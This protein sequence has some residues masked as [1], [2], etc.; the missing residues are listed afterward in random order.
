LPSEAK[1]PVAAADDT[2]PTNTTGGARRLRV[3]EE[4][5][6]GAF[7]R[8]NAISFLSLEDSES[9][10]GQGKPP[11]PRRQKFVIKRLQKTLR[12]RF[13]SSFIRTIHADLE[14]EGRILAQL[15]HPNIIRLHSCIPYQGSSQFDSMH[16]NVDISRT[17][18]SVDCS[19]HYSVG[20]S[21]DVLV[22]ERLFG[23][24]EDK[25]SSKQ[26]F[27]GKA[28]SRLP[29]VSHPEKHRIEIE[30][31]QR[32]IALPVASALTYLHS[33]RIIFVSDYVFVLYFSGITL[34]QNMTFLRS[35]FVT[36]AA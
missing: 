30:T 22:L 24:V 1:D 25:L 33:K 14:R 3:K 32:D 12:Q 20:S 7:N 27:L 15:S 35:L 18:L 11:P 5:G 13:T 23:T 9:T 26:S 19:G 2:P 28:L 17:G 8:V 4:L 10:N 6:R 36:H 34:S 31:R 21:K 16:G 29:F